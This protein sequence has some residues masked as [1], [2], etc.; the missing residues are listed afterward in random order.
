MATNPAVP[1]WDNA[2]TVTARAGAA[3][4]GKR[5]VGISG[6]MTEEQPTMTHAAAVGA[7]AARTGVS[8]YDAPAGGNVTVYSGT[9]VMPVTASVAI[10]AGDSIYAIADGRATNVAGTNPEPLGVAYGDAAIGADC[11][12][13]LAR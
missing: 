1:Y 12:V 8:A 9:Q 3:I 11:P 6:P 4:T 5:F 10:A 7:R 13:K 2:E